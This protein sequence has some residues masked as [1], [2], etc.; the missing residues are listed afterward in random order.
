MKVTF[1][2]LFFKVLE[3]LMNALPLNMVESL[4]ETPSST[5]VK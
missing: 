3:G 1:F 4:L 5:T 2:V